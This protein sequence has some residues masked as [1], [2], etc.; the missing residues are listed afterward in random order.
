MPLVTIKLARR[1]EP[2]A[3]DTKLA[4]ITGVTQLLVDTLAKRPDD[5]VVLIEELDPDNWGQGGQSATQLRRAR[6]AA[7]A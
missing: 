7:A 4:L 3:A 6:K 5:V 2:L 1:D